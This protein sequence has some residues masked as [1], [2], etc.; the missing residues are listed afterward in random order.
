MIRVDRMVPRVHV[1]E[2]ERF[3]RSTNAEIN[4]DKAN[5]VSVKVRERAGA[6]IIIIMTKE[7]SISGRNAV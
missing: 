6:E 4:H 5:E 3:G 2:A 7:M 1:G